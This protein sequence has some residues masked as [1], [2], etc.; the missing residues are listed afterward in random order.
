MD[1]YL[2]QVLDAFS[3]MDAPLIGE[4]LDPDQ[5]LAEV[6]LPIFTQ[7]LEEVFQDLRKFGNSFLEV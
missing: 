2:K 1:F 5:T 4:L 3:T 6:S 7:K